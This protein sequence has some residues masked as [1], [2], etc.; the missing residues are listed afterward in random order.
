[1]EPTA[2]MDLLDRVGEDLRHSLQGLERERQQLLALV[3]ELNG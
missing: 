2:R 3:G 1:M